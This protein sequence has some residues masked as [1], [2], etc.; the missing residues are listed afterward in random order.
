M[1]IIFIFAFL[2]IAA[3]SASTQFMFLVKFIGNISCS[4]I[5]S[6]NNSGNANDVS[7]RPPKARG[8]GKGKKGSVAA[9]I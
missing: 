3:C 1:E 5:S 6:R 8:K 4:R 2:A 9:S 7:T